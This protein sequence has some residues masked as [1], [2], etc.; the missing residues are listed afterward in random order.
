MVTSGSSRRP[1]SLS[2][3]RAVRLAAATGAGLAVATGRDRTAAQVATPA[4]ADVPADFKVVLHAAQADHWVYVQS[5][6]RNLI[7][8]WPRSHLRVVVDGNA[9]SGL[10]GESDLITALAEAITH[11]LELFICPNALREHGIPTD[12]IRLDANL[13]LG[14]V[15]ALVHANRDGYVYVK[16]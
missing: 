5:N 10:V 2:R 1:G 13:D 14:G 3:R 6:I 8:E 16:P 12:Q 11:G 7:E 9:V 4:A 15:I